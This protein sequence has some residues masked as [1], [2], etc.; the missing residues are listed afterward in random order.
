MSINIL[1]QQKTV[2]FKLKLVRLPST[3]FSSRKSS[4]ISNPSL[5]AESKLLEQ[6]ISQSLYCQTVAISPL[7]QVDVDG[8]RWQPRRTV[9]DWS[10]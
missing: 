9:T 7:V 6:A 5:H 2:N 4:A 3:G 8:S 1:G 10:P